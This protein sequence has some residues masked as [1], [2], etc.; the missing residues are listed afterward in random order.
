MKKKGIIASAV[1]AVIIVFIGLNVWNQRADGSTDQVKTT[2]LEEQE[3]EDTVMAPGELKFAD[4]Q[5]VYF[6]ED[7]G[8]VEEY[9]VDE[10]DEVEKGDDLIRYQNDDL[11]NE[12]K[13]KELQLDS[14]QLELEDIQK[15]REDLEEGTNEDEQ[16]Q[17][18]S[19]N[20]EPQE[21]PETPEGES[22]A[23]EQGDQSQG[24]DDIKRQEKQKKAE[25]EQTKAEQESLEK[26][27]EDTT[28]TSDI[29]GTIA[30]VDKDASSGAEQSEPEPMLQIGSLDSMRVEGEVSEYDALEINKEQAVKLTSDAVPDQSW[31]GEVAFISDL[32]KN[33]EGEEE[34]SGATYIVE[35]KVKDDDIDLKPGFE[36]LMEIETEA[37]Q[38]NVLPLTAV[39][40]DDDTD[41]VYVVNDGKAERKEVQTDMTT[42]EVI[43]ITDGLSDKENVIE[44]SDGVN[45]GMEVDTQ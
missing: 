42:N 6:Q 36:M 21:Q 4:E 41:Y 38:A 34:D 3:V 15:Q 17:S 11:E 9:V 43:E 45:E 8:E 19:D 25:I 13:Q 24:L 26:E 33:S 27:I 31:K 16:S 10:G 18:E 5:N 37:K 28:V 35:S 2:S 14:D 1:V 39:E 20:T 12:R 40:Q 7:K 29:D 23:E 44:D 30:A 22:G 32:P